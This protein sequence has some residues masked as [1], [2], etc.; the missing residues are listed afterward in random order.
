[1]HPLRFKAEVLGHRLAALAGVRPRTSLR[2]PFVPPVAGRMAAM[3]LAGDHDTLRFTIKHL[4]PDAR[5]GAIEAMLDILDAGERCDRWIECLRAWYRESREFHATTACL[6]G[7]VR[8]AWQ[9]RGREEGGRVP[10]HCGEDCRDACIDAARL[11]DEALA[12][13]PDNAGL[14]CLSL[15]VARTCGEPAAVSAERFARLCAV[16]PLHVSGHHAMLENLD[17]RWG[18]SDGAQLGFARERAVAAPDGHPLC[19]LAARA[20]LSRYLRLRAAAD[21]A[22][23]SVFLDPAVA[24]DVEAGWRRSVASP[25]FREETW[26]EELNN[27]F[28]AMLYLSGHV[29]HARLAL[30]ALDGS[31]LAEPWQALARTPRETAHPGWVVDRIRADLALVEK[32]AAG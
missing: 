11:L 16:A 9:Q 25:A 20:H 23:E 24:T 6:H 10:V 15:A 32:D 7:L 12:E 19:A 17:P 1:M 14:L 18:G 3:L 28:A 29:A 2:A 30:A 26:R 31:C 5:P 22:A 27:L 21:A 4:H 13:Q 8:Y